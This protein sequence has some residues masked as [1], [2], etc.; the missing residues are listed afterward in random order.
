M[1]SYPMPT[2]QLL[3]CIYFSTQHRMNSKGF[4]DVFIHLY[5]HVTAMVEE[6]EAP[7]VGRGSNGNGRSEWGG[8]NDVV[9][10][11]LQE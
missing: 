11:K 9:L 10:I 7:E 4:I 3:K 6:E 1:I 8:G 5:V 2:G